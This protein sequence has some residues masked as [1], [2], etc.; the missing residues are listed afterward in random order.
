MIYQAKMYRRA[1]KNRVASPCFALA[2][3]AIVP[4]FATDL[5]PVC[6]LEKPT[7]LPGE[8][9]WARA[10]F[11]TAT[12]ST[13]Y[14]WKPTAGRILR[15]GGSVLWNLSGVQPGEY[16]LSAKL[17]DGVNPVECGARLLVIEPAHERGELGGSLLVSKQREGVGRDVYGAYTYVLLAGAPPDARTRERY[18][19]VL[20][21]WQKMIPSIHRLEDRYKKAQ[22][23]ITYVPVTT[24]K[25]IQETA[26]WLLNNYDYVRAGMILRKFPS[27]TQRGP[28]LV[29]S[30]RPLSYQNPIRGETLVQNLSDVPAAMA[31]YWV[32]SFSRQAAQDQFWLEPAHV[33][34][35]LRMRTLLETAGEAIGPIATAVTDLAKILE[36]K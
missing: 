30:T 33:D 6:S 25:G 34:F 16:R 10:Q 2:L 35:A 24:V 27:E 18:L 8:T 26:E 4:L 28:Y 22:L 29:S 7:A 31:N 11:P 23:N 20:T 19:A 15:S 3:F 32:E 9:I 14:E 36:W 1:S 5:P 17:A 21:A 13:R 12:S